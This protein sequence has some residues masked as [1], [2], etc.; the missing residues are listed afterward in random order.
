MAVLNYDP[1]ADFPV[2]P[3]RAGQKSIKITTQS[4][5]L[6]SKVRRNFKSN[7]AAPRNTQVRKGR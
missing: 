3:E 6:T 7:G 5:R 1:Y 2:R 4:P